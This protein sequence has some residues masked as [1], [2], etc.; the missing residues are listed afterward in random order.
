MEKNIGSTETPPQV[1][2]VVNQVMNAQAQYLKRAR[3]LAQ[4]HFNVATPAHPMSLPI[5][6]TQESNYK[7]Q[8]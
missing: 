3:I 5:S 4:E 2:E 6:P 1:M 8:K 7:Q